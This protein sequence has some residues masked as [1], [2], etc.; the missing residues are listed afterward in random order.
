MNIL[1]GVT[2][3]IAAYKTPTFASVLK[4][5]G[6]EVRICVTKSALNFVAEMALATMSGN[7]VIKDLSEEVRGEV[8]H[9]EVAQWCDVF[10]VVPATANFIAKMAHGIADDALSTIHLALPEDKK[11]KVCPAMNTHMYQ[12]PIVQENIVKLDTPF[13][14]PPESGKLACGDE[15]IGKLPGTKKV[16]QFIEARSIVEVF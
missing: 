3:G 7:P 4:Q 13:I 12:N 8:T 10:V 1:L 6:H 5:K 15:G 11:V 2:G 16:I 9:I 14:L